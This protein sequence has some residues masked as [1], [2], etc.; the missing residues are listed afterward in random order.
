MKALGGKKEKH[1]KEEEKKEKAT[2]LKCHMKK[3]NR[4]RLFNGW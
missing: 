2:G 3:V 4:M 1:K